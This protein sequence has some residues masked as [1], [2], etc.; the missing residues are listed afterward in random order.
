MSQ[1][2]KNLIFYLTSFLIP[3][4]FLAVLF[5]QKQIW[6]G[7]PFTVLTYDLRGQ[8]LPIYA[9]LRY[10]GDLFYRTFG[11]LGAGALGTYAYYLGDPL[12][13]IS[14]LLPLEAF[15]DFL[16]FMELLK[17]GLCGLTF[18]VFLIRSG[19]RRNAFGLLV[20]PVC[21]ALM[22]YNILY[23][24]CLMWMDAVILLPLILLGVRQIAEG[25][26]PWL[27]LVTLALCLLC[28]YYIAWMCGIAA[29]LY[30][31]EQMT[32]AQGWNVRKVLRFAGASVLALGLSMPLVLPAVQEMFTGKLG[33]TASSDGLLMFGLTD[34]LRKFLPGEYD[35][36]YTGGLPSLYCGTLTLVFVAL[37][38]V[39]RKI[40]LRERLWGL[41][42]VLFYLAGCL[43]TPLY[44]FFHGF[45]APVCF[46]GR[47]TF[48]FCAFLL[49]FA[50]RALPDVTEFLK[51]RTE[52]TKIL[53]VVGVVFT[54]AELFLNGSIVQSGISIEVVYGPRVEY[55]G[56]LN[57]TGSLV[58]VAKDDSDSF[59]RIA[60]N[61]E[62]TNLDGYLLGYSGLDYFSS[63]Y[64]LDAMNL[65]GDLGMLQYHNYVHERGLTP[66]SES[67]YGLRYFLTNGAG[68]KDL[69]LIAQADNNTLYR[70]DLGLAPAFLVSDGISKAPAFTT[71]DFANQNAL[72]SDLLGRDVRVFETLNLETTDKYVQSEEK[73]N[74]FYPTLQ[75]SEAVLTVPHSGELWFSIG[76]LEEGYIVEPE[77]LYHWAPS[78]WSR[79]S[80]NGKDPIDC[81]IQNAP[82][83]VK[84]GYFEE[85]ETVNL[86]IES[87][88]AFSS[89]NAAILDRDAF[90]NVFAELQNGEMQDAHSEDG[91]ILSGTITADEAQTLLFTIP[92]DTGL[93]VLV[94]GAKTNTSSYRN[95]LLCTQ[96]PAGTHTVEVEYIPYSL[97]IGLGIMVVCLI[98]TL[99]WIRKG[100]NE[101]CEK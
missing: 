62:Y 2:N 64:N 13:W 28:N 87:V 63:S 15:P 25:R 59:S 65:F 58:K 41:G 9:S 50:Y 53:A 5:A 93:Q 19:E 60:K 16:Y 29:V 68:R 46:P 101:K 84:L 1:K 90:E 99:I 3:V 35:S 79:I 18:C 39:D 96:I 26:K 49:L 75:R 98:L 100:W 4:L 21:Y 14:A 33:E 57:T 34:V 36:I 66:V 42:I 45:R 88:Q 91:D 20:L 43:F 82:Y 95:A 7:G 27:Y 70:N 37:F 11:S 48:T 52:L 83:A 76:A 32:A 97:Y 86:V 54:V 77:G 51:S 40:A 73:M 72:L 22:S 47:F 80:V 38:F 55:T 89:C 74:E 17:V 67:F 81:A 92:Y 71:N 69:D 56:F 23:S 44:Y 30:L 94:D 8:Y 85:G 31:A 6:P 78:Y 24:M 61:Y 10:S 12:I